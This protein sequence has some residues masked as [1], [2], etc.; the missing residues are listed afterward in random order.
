M[1]GKCIEIEFKLFEPYWL[2][3]IVLSNFSFLLLL[4]SSKSLLCFIWKFRKCRFTIQFNCFLVSSWLNFVAVI[5]LCEC[6]TKV[7]ASVLKCKFYFFSLILFRYQQTPFD[8]WA[9]KFKFSKNFVC[10]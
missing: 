8:Y 1:N 6:L 5:L 10:Q 4:I 2:T 9:F 7:V 3:H